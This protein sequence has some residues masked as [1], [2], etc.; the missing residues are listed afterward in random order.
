MDLLDPTLDETTRASTSALGGHKHGDFAKMT[1]FG[2]FEALFQMYDATMNSKVDESIHLEQG[3][4]RTYLYFDRII[5]PAPPG[6]SR[7]E[8]NRFFCQ[9]SNLFLEGAPP[10]PPRGPPLHQTLTS[11]FWQPEVSPKFQIGQGMCPSDFLATQYI[12][13]SLASPQTAPEHPKI[14]DSE[15]QI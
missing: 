4:V 1:H 8:Q 14:P 10:A 11:D 13:G 3:T 7:G 2:G 15:L 5:N 6:H 12:L 9:I